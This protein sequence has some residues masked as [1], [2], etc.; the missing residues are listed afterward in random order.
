MDR[1]GRAAEL[2]EDPDDDVRGEV[3]V[4]PDLTEDQR[5]RVRHAF[6]T[7]ASCATR[8]TG[9][10]RSTTTPT[11]A[12]SGRVRPLVRRSVARA[13]RHV[14]GGVAVVDRRYADDPSPRLRRLALDDPESTTALVERLGTDAGPEVRYRAATDPRLSAASAVRLLDDGDDAVCAAAAR[15]P[16]PPAR[17]IRATIGTWTIRSGQT[18]HTRG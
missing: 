3:A 17:V 16:G 1:P 18:Q 2:A 6:E 7:R 10:W 12:P 8:S 4:R 14:P 15:H 13:R 9:S 5:A 11:H